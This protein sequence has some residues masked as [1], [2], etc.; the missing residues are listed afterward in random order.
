MPTFSLNLTINWWNLSFGIGAGPIPLKVKLGSWKG[1]KTWKFLFKYF[2]TNQNWEGVR[3]VS[4]PPSLG[5]HIH[6]LLVLAF[7]GCR[8]IWRRF[9]RSY[10]A[11]NPLKTTVIVCLEWLHHH[12]GLKPTQWWRRWG[13]A[14]GRKIAFSGLS[15]ALYWFLAF[16]TCLT[17]SNYPPVMK[18]KLHQL[19]IIQTR[20][21]LIKSTCAL[22]LWWLILLLTIKS[23]S[24]MDTIHW[25]GGHFY[26]T[27]STWTPP[28]FDEWQSKL[29]FLFISSSA[30]RIIS[31]GV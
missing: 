4:D 28:L 6:C 20:P 27:P 15:V 17:C 30:T 8:V 23:V 26:L 7:R 19:H 29:R 13:R 24:S 16:T 9:V 11:K 5:V 1:K 22:I 18:Q 14:S 25:I 12:T 10:K 21:G 2:Q 3:H 31:G